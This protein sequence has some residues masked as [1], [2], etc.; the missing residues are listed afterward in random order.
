[1]KDWKTTLTG[2]V[3][4]LLVIAQPILNGS[5]YRFDRATIGHIA[6]SVAIVVFGHLSADAVPTKQ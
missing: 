5:G 2:Y 4:G 3:L 6:I 1:M